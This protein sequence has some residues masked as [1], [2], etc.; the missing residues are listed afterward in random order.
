M[1]V[2]SSGT[3]LQISCQVSVSGQV[4][5]T[6]LVREINGGGGGEIYDVDADVNRLKQRRV[7]ALYR[8]RLGSLC[9]SRAAFQSLSAPSF[10]LLVSPGGLKDV[11]GGGSRTGLTSAG[12]WPPPRGM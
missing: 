12:E 4:T 5:Q 10:C 11:Y 6:G 3:C 7:P 1:C 8:R 9:N 2:C